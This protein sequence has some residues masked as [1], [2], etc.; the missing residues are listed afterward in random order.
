[1]AGGRPGFP[2]TDLTLMQRLLDAAPETRRQVLEAF[3]VT[4]WRPVYFHVR[5]GWSRP[6]EDAKDLTQGFFAW[7]MEDETLRRYASHR[8]SLRNFI[9]ELLRQF[10]L[11]HD[12]S[13]AR[14]KRGGGRRTVR[15]GRE[16][17]ETLPGSDRAHARDRLW[18]ETLMTRA[19]ERVRASFA[20]AGRG[21]MVRAFEEYELAGHGRPTYGEVAARLG[22]RESDV[23]NWLFAVREA[24]RKE[25]LADL[26]R[27]SADEEEFQRRLFELF[28]A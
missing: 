23:R 3:C 9:K 4:Y 24:I 20:T 28:D 7:L 17:A 18:V 14:L 27:Q 2:A 10:I 21:R 22:A 5:I 16:I 26:R 6:R 12:K 11:D 8:G 15:M 1:M 13:R 19:I 25:V